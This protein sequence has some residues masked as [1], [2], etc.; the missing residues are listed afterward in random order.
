MPTAPPRHRPAGQRATK[1]APDNRPSAAK[2]GYDAP[3]RKRR[4]AIY[5]RDGGKCQAQGCGRII[6]KKGEWHID[7]ITPRSA[8]GTEDD[9]NLQLLCASC[10]SVKTAREDGGF[11]RDKATPCT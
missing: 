10:H 7:H 11:G 8:G 9:S 6:G 4:L 1:R 3:W 5:V 2:R